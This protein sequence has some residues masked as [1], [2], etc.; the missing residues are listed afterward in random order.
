MHLAFGQGTHTCLG[1][2]LARKEIDLTF[3]TILRR[4][5]NIRLRDPDA[6]LVY[7]RNIALRSLKN[8]HIKFD[9]A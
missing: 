6:E 4:M 7:E 2:S 5:K 1:A 9:K 3:R 8:L